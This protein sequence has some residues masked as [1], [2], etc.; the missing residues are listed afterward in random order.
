MKKFLVILFVLSVLFGTYSKAEATG[1]LVI[2]RATSD[3][4]VTTKPSKLISVLYIANSIGELDVA[5]GTATTANRKFK[6]EHVVSQ[7]GPYDESVAPVFSNGVYADFLG[8]TPASATFVYIE[9]E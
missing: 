2:S 1:K 5:D 6:L 4:F 9:L 7:F 3:G 8:I